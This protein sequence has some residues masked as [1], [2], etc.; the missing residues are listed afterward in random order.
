MTG[1]VIDT[2]MIL[3]RQRDLQ[4]TADALA[5]AVAV[6][7]INQQTDFAQ[8]IQ[9]ITAENQYT[10]TVPQVNNP[11]LSGA[12]S[13]DSQFVEVILQCTSN[14]Y[15][16]QVL[17]SGGTVPLQARAVA[18]IQGVSMNVSRLE[19]VLLLDPGAVPGLQVSNI[20]LT[21]NGRVAVNS[22]SSDSALSINSPAT[23]QTPRLRVVGG[24]SDASRIQPLSGNASPLQA[25]WLQQ[26]D[27]LLYLPTPTTANGV[28]A[29][30][31]GVNGST[32]STPQDV[33][34]QLTANQSMTLAPGIYSSIEVTGSAGSLTFQPGIYILLGGTTSR[35][36][37][38]LNIDTAGSITATGV[39]CYLTGS[40]YNATTGAPD[41][42]DGNTR[43]ST[44]GNMGGAW[45]QGGTLQ[46]TALSD[47]S[48][49][50]DGMLL[51][52]RR[53]NTSSIT[54]ASN[55]Q[56]Q[57]LGTIYAR[58][59]PVSLGGSGNLGLQVVAGELTA[60]QVGSCSNV[61]LQIPSRSVKAC[62]VYLVE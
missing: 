28:L 25:G 22:T 6:D 11:P 55:S 33:A 27:P 18:G 7:L 32:F 49:P 9:N 43:G 26:N 39:L 14:V 50:F 19:Q 24:A 56:D 3:L 1:L 59:S 5:L 45:I 17:G 46:W 36:G 8:T 48:S 40:D 29:V 12:F 31:P 60:V 44:S 21:V 53:Q 41:C 15:F 61:T 51:Y 54:L 47:P 52:C 23:M 58:W 35:T 2:G 30:Y 42:N 62:Q 37:C 10:G 13:N 38:S 57:L 4:N 20:A 16:M 34:V